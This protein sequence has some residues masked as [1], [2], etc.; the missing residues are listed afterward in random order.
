[1]NLTLKFLR[2]CL[3]PR[4]QSFNTFVV[5][6]DVKFSHSDTSEH[7]IRMLSNI[8]ITVLPGS[9]IYGGLPH[10]SLTLINFLRYTFC[11]KWIA[12]D[13]PWL[14]HS[15][16]PS[17]T[18][19]KLFSIWK[20]EYHPSIWASDYSSMN[21][22]NERR[23][24]EFISR[25]IYDN[26]EVEN[27]SLWVQGFK[28]FQI[29]WNG[30]FSILLI[31]YC[32]EG[33]SIIIKNIRLY[34]YYPLLLSHLVLF[35][36]YMPHIIQMKLSSKYD[37]TKLLKQTNISKTRQIFTEKKHEKMSRKPQKPRLKCKY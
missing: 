5:F 12:K 14:W 18:A 25:S 1:M 21:C 10:R 37:K 19:P 24:W 4:T 2:N 11:Y 3:A 6:P 32:L 15:G 8:M 33:I 17:L 22:S 7:C 26:S 36:W 29:Y 16:S 23:V 20:V 35:I 31:Y 34:P 13:G 28:F 9:L 27:K 30:L